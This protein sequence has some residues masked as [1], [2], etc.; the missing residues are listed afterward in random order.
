MKNISQHSY[1]QMLNA[2]GNGIAIVNDV[3]TI[4]YAN[5]I[6]HEIFDYQPAQLLGQ[7]FDILMPRYANY[8]HT[9]SLL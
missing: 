8:E 4:V 6:L 2:C 5:S 1:E 3:S 7:P 9:S